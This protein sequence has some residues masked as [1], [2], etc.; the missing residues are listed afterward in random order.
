MYVATYLFFLFY[1]GILGPVT[2]ITSSINGC[3]SISVTWDDPVVVDDRLRPAYYNLTVYD[4]VTGSLMNIFKANNNSYQF[5]DEDLFIHRYLYVITGVNE[6][7]EGISNS[8]TFS[9]QRGTVYNAN[10]CFDI[11][12][13]VPQSII[14]HGFNITSYIPH[15]SSLLFNVPVRLLI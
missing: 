15:N 11:C 14:N 6:L 10:V 8:K 12:F 9:Y 4:N 1:K 7:G 5:E 13:I 3:S 2:N